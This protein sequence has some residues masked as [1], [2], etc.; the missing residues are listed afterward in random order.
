MGKALYQ[1]AASVLVRVCSCHTPTS[2]GLYIGGDNSC[3]KAH[4]RL[5]IFKVFNTTMFNVLQLE[6]KRLQINTQ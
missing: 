4:D 5:L 1:K 2:G 3:S 6:Y